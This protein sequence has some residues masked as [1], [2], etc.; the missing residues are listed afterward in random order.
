[1]IKV[2]LFWIIVI[3]TALSAC[4]SRQA[5]TPQTTIEYDSPAQRKA[6][7]TALTQ[8]QIKGRMAIIQ[9]KERESASVYWQR[10][11][12]DN[13]QTLSLTTYLGIQVFSLTSKNGMHQL[14]VDGENYKS[15]DLTGLLY[16]LT[17]LRLPV[18]QL[19]YWLFGLQADQQ[20]VITLHPDTQLPYSLVSKVNQLNWN[21][22][23]SDYKRFNNIDLPTKITIRQG[24]L[25]IKFAISTW[26]L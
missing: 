6:K 16:S 11:I 12:T 14:E 2:R 18:A 24:D 21:I 3:I 15:T 22:S 4:S 1:M 13:T 8:W 19:H 20:D 17:N 23:Y 26:T 5:I 7:I 10:N 25:L 9:G